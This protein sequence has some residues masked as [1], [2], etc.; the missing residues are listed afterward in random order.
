VTGHTAPIR[1][2]AALLERDGRWLLGQ[3][4]AHKRHGGQWEFPGG[5]VEAGETDAEAIARELREELGLAFVS[6][7]AVRG[8]LRD[9]DSPFEI[10]FV[11][12]VAEGEPV[13]HEHA[14][15]AWVAAHEF[16]AYVLAPSD[17]VCAGWLR[18]AD[19]GPSAR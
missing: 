16:E 8:V 12:V 7:G 3:R 6:L 10:T 9:G 1:V 18:A 15:L 4:P 2:L 17:V 19:G 5:K 13:A 14:A 11:D